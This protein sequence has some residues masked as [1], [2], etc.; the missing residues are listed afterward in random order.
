MEEL[1]SE[2]GRIFVNYMTRLIMEDIKANDDWIVKF[3]KLATISLVRS[4]AA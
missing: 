2:P 3:I 1:G 4:T